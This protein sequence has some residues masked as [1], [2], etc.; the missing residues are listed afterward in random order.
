[1]LYQNYSTTISEHIVS[2]V[3]NMITPPIASLLLCTLPIDS[4]TLHTSG[5]LC[6]RRYVYPSVDVVENVLYQPKT[7]APVRWW[8]TKP[9]KR[10]RA[11]HEDE[12]L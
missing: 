2:T 8:G 4:T 9:A 12:W 10:S 3:T 1:M 5:L 7:Y 11:S 6:P